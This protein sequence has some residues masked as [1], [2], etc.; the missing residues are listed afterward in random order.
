MKKKELLISC[1]IA[2][3]RNNDYP[4][5]PEIPISQQEEFFD[6]TI[7]CIDAINRAIGR[8]YDSN[9]L[10]VAIKTL[11]YADGDKTQYYTKYNTDDQNPDINTTFLYII[12]F[13]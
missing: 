1:I 10:P 9:K 12:L 4:I 2:T 7:T 6:I 8:C 3:G 5:D 11:S 13:Q